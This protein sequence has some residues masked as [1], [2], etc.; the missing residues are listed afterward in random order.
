MSNQTVFCYSC[1]MD[2]ILVITAPIQWQKL[3]VLTCKININFVNNNKKA[4]VLPY[5]ALPVQL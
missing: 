2:L 5:I 4:S 1:V 3:M